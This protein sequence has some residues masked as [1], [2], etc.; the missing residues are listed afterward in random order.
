VIK[1][2]LL[3][4]F[5]VTLQANIEKKIANINSSLENFDKQYSSVNTALSKTAKEIMRHERSL[6]RL[7]D[8][9]KKLGNEL[10]EKEK[11]YKS[12]KKLLEDKNAVQKDLQKMQ[13]DLKHKLVF[14][15]SKH[16]T[17]SQI[18]DDEAAISESSIMS[19]EIMKSLLLVTK[20]DVAKL[21]NQLVDTE[22]K[23]SELQNGIERLS[24]N[25]L[26]I[27]KKRQSAEEKAVEQ[28]QLL[29]KLDKKKKGHRKALELVISKQRSMKQTL[30]ELKI[31]KEEQIK[32]AIKKE[33]ERKRKERERELARKS[34]GKDTT[35]SNENLPKVKKQKSS[36]KAGKTIKY[37]G[38]KTIAPLKSY[39]VVKKFGNYVDPVYNI[40]IFNESVSLEP[41][42]KDAKVRNVLNGKVILAKSN[43]MLDN[44]IIIEH[45]DEM[46]TI[47]AN[48]DKIAPTI[49][50]GKRVKRGA[51]I[52]RINKPLMFEVTKKNY[53]INPLQMIRKSI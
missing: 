23:I 32:K 34:K 48:L 46:H 22:S 50:K 13:V 53:H 31:I 40:K 49:K 7:Q 51:V 33:K 43:P 30:K 39:K 17:I 28:V 47:Y 16:V 11:T 29:A 4:L 37:R 27:D 25:I 36:L 20:K 41:K 35:L 38:K 26:S 9:I 44:V 12:D 45:D 18:V 2:L 8:E 21:Q 52:G 5:V 10:V 15:L 19:E 14:T 3:F 42:N 24:N 6:V 1:T